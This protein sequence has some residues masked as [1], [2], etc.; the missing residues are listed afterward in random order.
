ME[1]WVVI[2]GAALAAFAVLLALRRP[3]GWLWRTAVRSA[4][5]LCGLWLFNQAGAF[6]GVQVGVNLL[7][8]LIL[9][10]LGVPGFGFLLL[11]QWALR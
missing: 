8:G 5:G 3:L 10:V 11:A 2:L 4:A 9:G 6:I 1:R 7:S